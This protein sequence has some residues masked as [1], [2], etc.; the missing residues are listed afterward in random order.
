M[1][2]SLS[3]FYNYQQ[4]ILKGYLEVSTQLSAI[5]KYKNAYQFKTNEV[6]ELENALSTANELYLAGYAS[7]LEVPH[8]IPR[9]TRLSG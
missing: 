2:D 3:A 4:T 9:P 8:H 5:D 6:K 7:Y 1:Q